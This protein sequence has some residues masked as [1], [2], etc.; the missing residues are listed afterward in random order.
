MIEQLLK[1]ITFD[2]L[3]DTEVGANIL[4]AMQGVEKAQEVA[5]AYVNDDSPDHLK[6]I[7]VGTIAAFSTVSKVAAGKP[8]KEFND[9]DWK[10]IAEKVADYAVLPDGQQYS[11]RIFEA[12]ADYVDI[13]V[14]VLELNGISQEKRDA[15][16]AI[17]KKVRGLS[18]ELAKGKI[19][20]VDYTEQCLWLLLEA[21]IK[22]LSTYSTI[23]VG[24]ELA[25][26]SQ[27]LGMLAFEYGRYALYKQ[28]LEILNQY[29][30]H[31]SDVDAELDAKLNA[32][33]ETLQER[34]E[35]FDGFIEDAFSPDIQK[36]L[37][38][39]V[40][41]ARNAGVEESEILDSVEKI[42]EFFS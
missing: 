21:M 15:I 8:I 37:M 1:D 19:A 41:L 39:S 34:S 42:D 25:D 11:V 22:L 40:E 23:I 5:L 18:K 38:S 29:M 32:F 35:V 10:D 36:R 30:E 26:F 9:Q 3:Q 31:Q 33:K 13:S 2:Y 14:K 28:E 24:E 17:A 16:S 6:M 20:E 12:Y 7:R 4:K 27:S